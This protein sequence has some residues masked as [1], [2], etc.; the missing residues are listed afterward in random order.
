MD[1]KTKQNLIYSINFYNERIKTLKEFYNEDNA[2]GKEKIKELKKI[3]S[4]F[5]K[6][7]KAL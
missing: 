3:I 5:K 2:E 4:I 6:Q 1:E 7:L